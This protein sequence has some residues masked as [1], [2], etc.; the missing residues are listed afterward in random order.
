MHLANSRSASQEIPKIYGIQSS[1]PSSQEAATEPILSRMDL[2]YTCRP[3]S[4]RSTLTLSFHLCLVF[5][6]VSS[7]QI[8]IK[9]ACISHQSLS[10]SFYISRPSHPPLFNHPNNDW[11]RVQI[12]KYHFVQS[13]SHS[14]NLLPLRF[15]YFNG[16]IP[17]ISY[18]IVIC[19]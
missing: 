1:L 15:K 12:L 11:R 9:N 8:F 10:H 18:V 17:K 6:V 19:I 4:L 3:I 2:V 16:I 13:S 7:F 14:C 5:Q